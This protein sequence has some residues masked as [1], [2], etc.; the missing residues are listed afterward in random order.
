MEQFIPNYENKIQYILSLVKDVNNIQILEL[1][2]REG[3]STNYFLKICKKKN[4]KLISID[5]D[6]CSKVSNDK[7]W[8]FIKSRDDNFNLIDTYLRNKLDLIY[9]DSY[10]EPNHIKKVFYH[11]FKFLKI[12]GFCI[13]DDISWLPYCKGEYRDNQFIENINRSIFNKILQIYN[14]NKKKFS[15]EFFF[16]GS[17]L[18]II[19]KK[20]S[21]LN[22][23]KM[24]FSREFSFKNIIKKIFGIKPKK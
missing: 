3:I 2:V 10:H 19:K 22:D 23:S 21:Q 13:I 8:K 11:Y 12:G 9:I 20:E 16:E 7:N 15:L 1:G 17:G 6:D 14:Q 24:I 5:I 18:A 4:G